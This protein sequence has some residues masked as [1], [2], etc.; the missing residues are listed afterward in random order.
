M[1]DSQ[2]ETD[3]IKELV[4]AGAT[5][6]KLR[7]MTVLTEDDVT[8]S[9]NYKTMMRDNIDALKEEVYEE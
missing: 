2:E 1:L 4:S 6:K 3:T 7:S 9:V 8:N 5:V